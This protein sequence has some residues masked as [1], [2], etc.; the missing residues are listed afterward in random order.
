MIDIISG[1]SNVN[2]RRREARLMGECQGYSHGVNSLHGCGVSKAAPGVASARKRKPST[3]GEI[4]LRVA[5]TPLERQ[6][7][8]SGLGTHTS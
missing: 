4:R 5:T 6:P 3:G 1:L 2:P 8:P 7:T